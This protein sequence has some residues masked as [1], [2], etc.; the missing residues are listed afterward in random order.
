MKCINRSGKE[1]EAKKQTKISHKGKYIKMSDDE[2]QNKINEIRNIDI[3]GKET[4][5]SSC[6]KNSFT[7]LD[8]VTDEVA[9]NEIR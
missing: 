7:G 6:D 4:E 2:V 9:S 8:S 1:H 5:E 3:S